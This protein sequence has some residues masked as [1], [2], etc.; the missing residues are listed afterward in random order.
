MMAR[1]LVVVAVWVGGLLVIEAA[2]VY[3]RHRAFMKQV[4]ILRKCRKERYAPH[5]VNP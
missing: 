5:V 4:E 3:M 2:S 1:T